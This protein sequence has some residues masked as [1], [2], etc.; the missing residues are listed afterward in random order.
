MAVAHARNFAQTLSPDEVHRWD[1][2]RKARLQDGEGGARNLDELL[3]QLDVLSEGADNKA[4]A[5]L[6]AL[7]DYAEQILSD[8]D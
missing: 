6:D 2:H 1:A 7:S 4:Q 8:I 3:A 5:V